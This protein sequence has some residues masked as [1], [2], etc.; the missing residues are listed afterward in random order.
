MGNKDTWGS[1]F[2]RKNAQENWEKIGRLSIII[3]YPSH[4][5]HI[6]RQVC[7]RKNFK[8]C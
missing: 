7:L 4:K 2:G 1:A 3:D 6:C 5:R 8:P